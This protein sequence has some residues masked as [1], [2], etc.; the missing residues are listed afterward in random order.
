MHRFLSILLPGILAI[1]VWG[2]PVPPPPAPDGWC[3]TSA[4]KTEELSNRHEW[5][6]QRRSEQRIGA[7]SITGPRVIERNGT[8]VIEAD[9]SILVN[10]DPL[11][12]I[13]TT[14]RL[15]PAGGGYQTQRLPIDYRQDVG[16]LVV[17]FGSSAISHYAIDLPFSFPFRGSKYARIFVTNRNGIYF[18][19]P[20]TKVP[21]QF[22]VYD[23]A[24][25]DQPV[26]AP[27]L[28]GATPRTF[29]GPAFY[30]NI[31]PEEIV[32][33][34]RAESTDFAY[35]V[36]ARLTS[37][38][39]I[40][41]SWG[42]ARDV[43][44]GAVVVTSGWD[45]EGL[46]RE[47]VLRMTDRYNDSLQGRADLD[48]TGVEID[49][50]D[51]TDL[52][53]V[54]V[55]IRGPVQQSTIPP[56]GYQQYGLTSTVDRSSQIVVHITNEGTWILLPGRG[57]IQDPGSLRLEPM[58]I[59]F[60]IRD[61]HLETGDLVELDTWIWD[62][63]SGRTVD[64]ASGTFPHVYSDEPF[65]LDLSAKTSRLIE[66]PLIEA[67][68]LPDM[69]PYAVWDLLRR[70]YRL[71][72]RDT[73]ALAIYQN[74]FTD[75]VLYAGA[76]STVGNPGVDGVSTRGGYGTTEK[77][78]PALLHMSRL[79]YRY[80]TSDELS[81]H[82]LNHEFGHRWLYFFEIMEDG[83]RSRALNPGGGHPA[84]YVH[85]PAAF[86]V[87]GS[88]NSSAMGGSWF[89]DL[90]SASFRAR[91]PGAAY[92]FSWHELYLMGLARP[93]EVEP[94][95]YIASSSPKLG[96][97]YYPPDG[98]LVTGNRRDVTIDQL[99]DAMGPRVP[100]HDLSRKRFSAFFVLLV[101]DLDQ[102]TESEIQDLDYRRRLLHEAIPVATGGRATIDTLFDE[103]GPRRR[104]V[105]RP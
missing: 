87:L 56:G 7:R 104:G 74:F 16:D 22:D 91:N 102:L 70:E 43:S 32:V 64:R 93:D 38:G 13:G 82:V 76:Y 23:A 48:L 33:T 100:D 72:D 9:D 29:V 54:R 11:D 79:G 17:N 99:I 80:N 42:S 39:G 57:W 90:G 1:S 51:G 55:T 84:Q 15:E 85:T 46:T 83:E 21:T 78:F 95:F 25:I 12:L 61:H 30:A 96:D 97:A 65:E 26:I 69:D 88:R 18:E 81:T 63:A 66:R 67:F 86:D 37:A 27:L 92:G 28:L 62:S 10:D 31:S 53:E 103:G 8:F 20:G 58:A 41:L 44:W 52:L 50:L 89:D 14:I 105:R 36:Q 47:P 3:A 75:L 24:S 2:Q 49:R 35:D 59:R 77:L 45:G 101:R 40:D 68:T 19:P 73:D 6:E 71:D 34:W 60:L 5:R 94:W 98:I 4:A